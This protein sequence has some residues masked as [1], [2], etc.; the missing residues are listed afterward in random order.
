MLD[1][2][3]EAFVMY[4]TSFNLS[5]MLIHPTKKA[6]IASLITKKIKILVKYLDFSNVFPTKEGFNIT[7]ANQT[8][9]TYHQTAKRS[10]TIL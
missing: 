6:Q 3:V 4:V 7:K 10:A 5:L 1:K 2:N 9:L 8:Q